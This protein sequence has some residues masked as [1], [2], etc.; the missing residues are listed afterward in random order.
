M[1]TA[2]MSSS[3][4]KTSMKRTPPTESTLIDGRWVKKP[5]RMSNTGLDRALVTKKVLSYIGKLNDL[6]SEIY[7][8]KNSMKEE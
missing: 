2:M 6:M 4:S 1:S 8:R 7:D 5:Q 3:M